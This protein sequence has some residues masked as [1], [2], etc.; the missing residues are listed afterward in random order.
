MTVFRAVEN[1]RA[2]ARSAN[3]GISGFVDP[4]GRILAS[5][6]LL[7]EAVIT[8]SV[9]LIKEKTIY[10]RIGDLF[11]QGCLVLVLLVALVE[12]VRWQ[13]KKKRLKSNSS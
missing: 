12:I 7:E 1:R 13:T 8:R 4:A 6:P 2:L 10:S 5:T 9:P 3:T 11:A